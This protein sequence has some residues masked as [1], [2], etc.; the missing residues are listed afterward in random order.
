MRCQFVDTC[1]VGS[2][3][4][5][6]HENSVILKLMWPL[7]SAAEQWWLCVLLLLCFNIYL[8]HFYR[9]HQVKR[10]KSD[11]IAHN[12]HTQR[13][14]SLPVPPENEITITLSP[15]IPF[16]SIK[17]C[18]LSKFSLS[19]SLWFPI[20]LWVCPMFILSGFSCTHS[21]YPEIVL[22]NNQFIN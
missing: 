10:V 12:S 20:S 1:N 14:P 3:A 16:F 5:T 15:Q 17:K 21:L 6:S 13:N 11:T 19:L 7:C 8:I 4:N 2:A 18:T 22:T 9:Q